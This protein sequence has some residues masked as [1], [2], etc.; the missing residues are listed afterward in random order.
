MQLKPLNDDVYTIFQ[1][2]GAQSKRYY[3]TFCGTA[4]LFLAM[5]SFLGKNK[6]SEVYKPVYDQLKEI[7]NRYGV[8]GK[9]FEKSFLDFCPQ[10]TY[11]EGEE[12]NITVDREYKKVRENL[13]RKAVSEKR[14]QMIEDFIMELFADRSYMIRQIFDDITGSSNKTDK[15]YDEIIK[16]FKPL[17]LPEVTELEELTE[18]TNLNKW[19]GKH[20]QNIIDADEP[21]AK[22]EMGLAG[23]S[24][25]NVC[26]TGKAGTGKT[27]YVYEFV[28][29]IVKGEVPEEFKNKIVY[30]VNTGALVAGTKFRGRL[31][32]LSLS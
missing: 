2:A 32:C 17:V 25:R 15:M 23:R 11:T 13:Q 10:G 27:C 24:I 21:V 19:V 30:E 3:H 20:P 1:K 8:D 4:H 22:M 12:F 6:E 28:Q 18:L 5:F 14:S 31:N 9:K 7:L 26:L 29:R 16:T